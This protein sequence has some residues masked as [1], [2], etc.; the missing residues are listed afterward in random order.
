MKL[1]YFWIVVLS[2]CIG[3]FFA[4]CG[5][6]KDDAKSPKI[7][8]ALYSFNRFSLDEAVEKAKLTGVNYIE[9]FFFHRIGGEFGDRAV[10]ELNDSEIEKVHSMLN[11]NQMEMV[12]MYADGKTL[13]DWEA[14]FK[15]GQ[16]L[17]MQFLVGE[18]EPELWDELNDLA[19]KYAMKLA[20]HEHAKGHSRFWHPDSVLHALDGRDNFKVCAD[21]GHWVRSGLDPVECLQKLEGH[22]VSVHAKDLDTFGNIEA[23]DVRMGDGVIDYSAVMDELYRQEYEGFIFVECEHDWDDNFSDLKDGILL[24]HQ[25]KNR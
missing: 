22:I 15:K 7:G 5:F 11:R 20:I 14:L 3:L 8:V 18:P 16:Q 23:E 12:S 25:L 6:Q 1:R 13:A 21:L 9:G 10:S 17:G 24:L 4:S 2:V 19:G